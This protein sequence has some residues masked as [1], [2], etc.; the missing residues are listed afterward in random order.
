MIITQADRN[1]Y[2]EHKDEYTHILSIVCPDEKEI[3]K[4]LHDNHIITKMWDIDKPLKNKFR[5]YEPPNTLEINVPIM[6]IRNRWLDTFKTHEDFRLLIH[7]DAG[8]SRS[9]AMTLGLLWEMSSY[10]FK[11]E[12]TAFEKDFTFKPYIEARK[13]WCKSLLDWNNSVSLCRYI[14]GRLNPGVKPNQAILEYF[15]FNYNY[16]PW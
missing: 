15:R 3:I 6:L 2:N 12:L 4:P 11:T 9:P 16:F 8:V 10:I 1:F 13:Q 14:D 7:C 5:E